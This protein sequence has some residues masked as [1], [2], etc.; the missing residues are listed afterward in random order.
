MEIQIHVGKSRLN[1]LYRTNT[2]EIW[3]DHEVRYKKL[4]KAKNRQKKKK[5]RIM[6]ELLRIGLQLGWSYERAYHHELS[7]VHLVSCENLLQEPEH[8]TDLPFRPA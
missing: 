1:A 6:P 2:R 4:H 5:P 8:R 7:I 3:I